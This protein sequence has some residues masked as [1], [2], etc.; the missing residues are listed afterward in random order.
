[1]FSSE[2]NNRRL[3]IPLL[4]H[5]FLLSDGL[6]VRVQLQHSLLVLQWVLLQHARSS[7]LGLSGW[8][9]NSLDLSRTNQSES[10]SVG[11]N[12]AR[13]GV[14][15]LDGLGGV[16]AVDGVQGL[17]SSL[18]PDDK[19]TQVGTGSQLQQ[20]QTRHVGGVDT[21]DVSQG[22]G[23]TVVVSVDDQRTLSLGESSTSQLTLTSSHSLGLDDSDDVLVGTD[24]LQNGN[25]VLGLGDGLEVVGNNQRQLL[26]LLN[27][28]ASG[29][30]QR[31][32]AG[33]SNSRGS[34]VTLLVVVDSHVPSSPGLGWSEHTTTPTHVTE[35]TLAGTVGTTTTDSWDSGDSTSGTPGLGG[36]L[37]TSLAGDSVSLSLVLVDSG[38]D[39]LN[40]VTS[41]W[42]SKN[43]R[44]LHLGGGFL[45]LGGDD[46]NLWTGRHV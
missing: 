18:G 3:L 2:N 37:V 34:G 15:D 7:G 9:D 36:G 25:G 45:T 21:W 35:S 42:S 6:G 19:S 12:V 17:E 32:H 28:V 46:G 43:S 33:S 40:N 4:T 5:L 30:N 31:S 22:L 38:E 27:L 23:D 1:M 39:R 8:S 11:D 41:D 16:R 20:A 13:Q 10:V 26:H 44:Q 24:G 14:V 29:Q